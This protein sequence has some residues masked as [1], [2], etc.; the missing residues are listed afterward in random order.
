M[1]KNNFA[2]INIFIILQKQNIILIN[3]GSNF[4]G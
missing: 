3:F 1:L 2:I 4:I